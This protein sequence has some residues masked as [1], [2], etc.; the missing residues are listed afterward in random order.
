MPLTGK[1]ED[2]E[3]TTGVIDRDLTLTGTVW[4]DGVDKTLLV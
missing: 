3:L 1:D 4:W 2:W